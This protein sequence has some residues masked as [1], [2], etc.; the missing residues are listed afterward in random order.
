M[1]VVVGW[2]VSV[3][4]RR[5]KVKVKMGKEWRRGG[6]EKLVDFLLCVHELQWQRRTGCKR[7]LEL[8]LRLGKCRRWV[9]N[10]MKAQLFPRFITIRP[11][12]D[13]IFQ[14]FE[15]FFTDTSRWSSGEFGGLTAFRGDLWS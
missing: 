10:H 13:Q 3:V 7:W 2:N 15:S 6:G 9:N 5:Q 14:N 8:L 4:K 12:L 11:I 1:W